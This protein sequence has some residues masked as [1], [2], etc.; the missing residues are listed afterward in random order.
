MTASS[1]PEAV[2]DAAVN[3]AAEV[4]LDAPAAAP[5]APAA[6][7]P[8]P[9]DPAPGVVETPQSEGYH[10][11]MLLEAQTVR[12]LLRLRVG[13]DAVVEQLLDGEACPPDELVRV[14]VHNWSEGGKNWG[15]VS[16]THGPAGAP[17]WWGPKHQAACDRW[18]RAFKWLIDQRMRENGT[19]KM[20]NV[21]SRGRSRRY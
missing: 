20:L 14:V 4:A 3:A 15:R 16:L 11:R 8:A 21:G 10:G 19:S 12:N 1:I 6:A 17:V 9:A 2:Q 5:D 18:V 7:P 13:R